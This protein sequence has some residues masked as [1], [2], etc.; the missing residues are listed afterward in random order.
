MVGRPPHARSDAIAI[1]EYLGRGETFELAL[2]T[3]A[4]SYADQNQRDFDRF[5]AAATA[6]EIKVASGL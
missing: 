1:A 6:G 5:A 4:D 2:A 3:F